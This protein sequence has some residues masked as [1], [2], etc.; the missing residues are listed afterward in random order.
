MLHGSSEELQVTAPLRFRVHVPSACRKPR[1]DVLET[2]RP[3]SASPSR[4]SRRIGTS[5]PRLRRNFV[6]LDTVPLRPAATYPRR[7]RVS[8][9]SRRSTSGARDHNE[10][11]AESSSETSIS[12][13]RVQQFAAAIDPHMYARIAAVFHGQPGD[14]HIAIRN[15]ASVIWIPCTHS[16]GLR[17]RR[18]GG[19]VARWLALFSRAAMRDLKSMTRSRFSVSRRRRSRRRAHGVS[20]IGASNRV[21]ALQKKSL[22]SRSINKNRSA[23]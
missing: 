1:Y 10:A 14:N 8:G 6:N 13:A 12:I 5:R 19:D 17:C 22:L 7:A 15:G 3:D 9:A 16:K 23:H 21:S 2:S 18:E 4:H 20:S 11:P